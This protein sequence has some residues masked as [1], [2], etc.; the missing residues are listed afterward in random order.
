MLISVLLIR[1]RSGFKARTRRCRDERQVGENDSCWATKPRSKTAPNFI[2]KTW[3][4]ACIYCIRVLK[5][6]STECLKHEPANGVSCREFVKQVPNSKS[7][8][9]ISTPY[10]ILNCLKPYPPQENI[11]AGCQKWA[12]LGFKPC[13]L[14][15]LVPWNKLTFEHKGKIGR[16]WGSDK[17][18]RGIFPNYFFFIIFFWLA[19]QKRHI[20]P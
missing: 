14:I 6:C 12:L 9:L 20:W 3:C 17:I 1:R 13:Y 11:P 10:A 5:Y 2:L 18:T 8:S 4:I 15:M 7:K 16:H 19:K